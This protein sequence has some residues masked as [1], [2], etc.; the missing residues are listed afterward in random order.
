M[1]S[2]V[3]GIALLAALALLAGCGSGGEGSDIA[4]VS[5]RDGDYAVFAMA[6][7]GGGQHRLTSREVDASSP[8][9]LF[10]Q[11]EPAWSPDGT[12]IAF[13]SRRAGTFDV[14]VMNADGT[15]TTKLTS[16]KTADRHPTYSPDGNRIAFARDADIY[17]MNA[18]GTGV[19]RV[20]GVDAEDFEPAWSPDGEWIAYVRRASGLVAKELWLMRPDGSDPHALTKL[21]GDILQPAWSPD[22]TRIAFSIKTPEGSFY[23]L[24]TIGTD[25]KG[26]REVV[27]TAA[28]NFGPS[29]S[30][31]GERIAYVEDGAVF[32]VE[33]G[34]G[35]ADKLT[36]QESNDLSPTWN[37]APPSDDD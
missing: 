34:G 17:V 14:Y 23:E 11:V 1:R 13:A 21:D 36:S 8:Q 9:A 15:A 22:G 31:D 12:K 20:S 29:W 19:H 3:R 33:L 30:P 10:F 16:G 37:P 5:V 4:F 2:L 27:P 26:L 32:A 7:D 18:D 35:E 25:G 28:D 24:R 6:A